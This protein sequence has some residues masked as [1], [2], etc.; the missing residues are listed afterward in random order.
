MLAKELTTP[1]RRTAFSVE[2]GQLRASV[3]SGFE[4]R[5]T[6]EILQSERTRMLLVAWWSGALATAFPV[7]VLVSRQ[8]YARIFGTAWTAWA[9]Q[10][11]AVFVLLATYELVIRQVVGRRLEK[12]KTLPRPLRVLNAFVETS[13]PRLPTVIAPP[14]VYPVSPL[15]TAA[16]YLY[17]VFIVLSTLRLDF[18][19]SVF[20]GCVAAVEY[21][22]LSAGLVPGSGVAPGALPLMR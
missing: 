22:I 21:V 8:D 6:R 13:R 5:L 1:G 16:A 17:P 10:F 19:L 20:T 11:A 18:K 14:L 12:G 7:F 15:P 9:V 2:A 4:E 3:T